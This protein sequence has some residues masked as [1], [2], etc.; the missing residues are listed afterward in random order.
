MNM[1]YYRVNIVTKTNKKV[2]NGEIICKRI[3]AQSVNKYT[4]YVYFSTLCQRG[5]INY[6]QKWSCP[7]NSPNYM[8]YSQGYRFLYLVVFYLK[9]NQF[10]HIKNKYTAIKAANTMLKSRIDK[11]LREQNDQNKIIST[12]SCR[13]CKVCALKEFNPCKHFDKMAYSFEALGVN[14]EK[15]V[16]DKMKHRLLWYTKGKVP[17]YTTVVAGILSNQKIRIDDFV[18][19]INEA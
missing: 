14:V 8:E 16:M 10:E 11:H 15:L 2:Y 19:T 12:G 1:E 4:D 6:G 13:L 18:H 7:P 3:L 5:C 9:M 17:E